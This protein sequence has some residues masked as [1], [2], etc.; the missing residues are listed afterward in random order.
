MA[1]LNVRIYPDP[2]LSEKSKPLGAISKKDIGLIDNMIE[3]MYSEDGVGLAAPQVG[4]SK[5]IIVVSPNAERRAECV[6]INPEIIESSREQEV[7]VEGCLSLPGISCEV[8]RAR[9]IK[10]KALDLNGKERIEEALGFRARVIQHE[11]DHL[12]GVLLIDRLDFDG[13]QAILGTYRRL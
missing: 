10:L 1:I 7:D 5:R 12:N 6:Y 2:V 13:R 8:F 4:V 3:T 11:I 9:R